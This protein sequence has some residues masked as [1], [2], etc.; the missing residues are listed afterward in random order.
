LETL[1][2]RSMANEHRLGARRNTTVDYT[3]VKANVVRWSD[4]H[5]KCCD[6]TVHGDAPCPDPLFRLASRGKTGARQDFLQALGFPGVSRRRD[7]AAEARRWTPATRCFAGFAKTRRGSPTRLPGWH[8]IS[9]RN[10]AG[11]LRAHANRPLPPT[12]HLPHRRRRCLS[13]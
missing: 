10:R 1:A 6:V 2:R 13:F 8:R 5:A 11:R 3:A 12:A 7:L 4:P 9:R